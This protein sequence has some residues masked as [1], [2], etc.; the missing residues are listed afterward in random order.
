MSAPQFKIKLETPIVSK[1]NRS[2]IKKLIF[3]DA[4]IVGEEFKIFYT[5]VNIGNGT[6]P[7]GSLL[8]GI[9]WPNGQ[10]EV[11]SYKI[12]R[13][14]PGEK[15]RTK[16]SQWGILAPGFA[17]FYAYLTVPSQRKK[18]AAIQF[19]LYRD[20]KNKLGDVSFFSIFGQSTEEFYQYWAIIIAT[21]S[22]LIIVIWEYLIPFLKWLYSISVLT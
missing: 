13:L 12:S 1:V 20:E 21:I 10:N 17:L 6:F 19:P 5:L 7:G 18:Q 14:D 11:A 16:I 4:F 8:I 22:L 2:W 15:H 9:R 3:K